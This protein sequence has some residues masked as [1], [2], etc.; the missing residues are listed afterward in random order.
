M[1]QLGA[2]M[3]ELCD[4][5]FEKIGSIFKEGNGDYS[6]GECL[7]PSLTWQERD[8]LDLDRGPF[9]KEHDY[10]MSLISAFTSH[11]QELPLTSHTFFAP[12]P[13]RL[14]YKS[15]ASYGTTMRRWNDFVAIGQKIDHSKNILLYSMA[16]QF[17]R[18]MVPYLSGDLENNFTLSHPD[19]HPGNLYVDDSLNITCIIDW[20]SASTGPITELLTTPSLGGS[21][22]PPSE[23]LIAAFRSGF[24]QRATPGSPKLIH[25]NLWEISE[26]MWYFSRLVRLLSK[27]DYKLFQNLFELIYKTR[28]EGSRDSGGILLL[29]HERANQAE[30]KKLLTELQEDDLTA[31]ELEEKERAC[32]PL[33][34]TK[35]SDAIAVA[36]KLTLMSEMNPGFIAD[37]R[38]WQWVEEA[39]NHDSSS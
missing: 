36:R 27:N 16:G 38:L 20:T 19:L 2:I 9:D 37:H 6:V 17:L 25:S 13:D 1:S 26:R 8:S 31:E 35:D 3:S 28:T 34:R 15:T 32:F 29:F 14:D 22:A 33:S 39:R 7:S 23:F 24:S 12:L 4:C 30:N 18:E 5:R 10:H 11:A 21:A